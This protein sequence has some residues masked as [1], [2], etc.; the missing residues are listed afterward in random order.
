MNLRLL[1]EMVKSGIA[2]LPGNL[3]TTLRDRVTEK[4]GTEPENYDE[5]TAEG[6]DDD[7]ADE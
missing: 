5:E 7:V 6:A 4:L 2:T 1:K 3:K